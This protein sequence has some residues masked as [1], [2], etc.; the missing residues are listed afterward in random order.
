ISCP[1]G[2]PFAFE[3]HEVVLREDL[4]ASRLLPH[5]VV[6]PVALP[7]GQPALAELQEQPVFL[8]KQS[9]AADVAKGKEDFFARTS[10]DIIERGAERGCGFAGV[11][12]ERQWRVIRQRCGE[13]RR[14]GAADRRQFLRGSLREA[15]CDQRESHGGYLHD[16]AFCVALLSRLS[17]N[18]STASIK[19]SGWSMLTAWPAAGITTFCAPGILAAM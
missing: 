4:F 17:R 18:G 10:P 11:H 19:A 9:T 14:V 15:A 3:L 12:A 2:H 8:V 5:P 6:A 1:T 16:A 13:R 7:A